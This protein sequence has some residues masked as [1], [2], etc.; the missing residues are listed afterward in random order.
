MI[1]GETEIRG[2][3]RGETE[4]DPALKMVAGWLKKGE[5]P[6]SIQNTMH[7]DSLVSLWK[8]YE[9]LSY[10]EGI[11]YRRWTALKQPFMGKDLIV[12]PHVLQERLLTYSLSL[13]SFVST[14][15]G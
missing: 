11:V 9:L 3:I 4:K 15:R 1:R 14:C 13:W 6:K 7:P 5:R 8:S 2:E 10:K 12:V